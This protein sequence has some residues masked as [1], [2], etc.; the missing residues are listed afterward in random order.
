M[1][2]QDWFPL[3]WTGWIIIYQENN[4]EEPR[5][6]FVSVKAVAIQIFDGDDGSDSSN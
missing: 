5:F 1:N 2:I 6:A 3:G 4:W